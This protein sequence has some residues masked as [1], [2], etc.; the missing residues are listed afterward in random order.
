MCKGQDDIK[1]LPVI[2]T[3][4]T[5]LRAGFGR[6]P[7]DLTYTGPIAGSLGFAQNDMGATSKNAKVFKAF[8]TIRYLT[9]ACR[10]LE[11][12]GYNR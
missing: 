4:S 10:G 3:P 12:P 11:A 9:V 7:S 6:N 8:E 1:Q 2:S 5:A